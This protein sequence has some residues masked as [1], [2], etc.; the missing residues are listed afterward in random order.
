MGNE[1]NNVL[2]RNPHHHVIKYA[3]FGLQT[4]RGRTNRIRTT[5]LPLPSITL[6]IL[7]P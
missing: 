5:V 7:Y 1:N 2:Y 4:L 3:P 6:H